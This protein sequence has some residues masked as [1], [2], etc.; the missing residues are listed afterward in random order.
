MRNIIKNTLKT[1]PIQ[2]VE[3]ILYIHTQIETGC[4]QD[5]FT[6]KLRKPSPVMSKLRFVTNLFTK[7]KIVNTL[8][9]RVIYTN[10]N[11]YVHL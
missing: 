9:F 8:I 2:I 7:F 10:K 6:I 4:G 1:K 3:I 5:N 11:I